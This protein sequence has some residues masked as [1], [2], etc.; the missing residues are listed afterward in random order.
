VRVVV[1]IHNDTDTPEQ[2]HWHGL[3]VPVDADGAS[4]EGTPFI[5]AHGMRR[6]AYTPRP[7]GFRFYHSHVIPKADLSKGTY[8]GQ[9][10][11]Y[12]SNQATSP[13]ATTARFFSCS[14]NLSRH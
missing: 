3:A 6:V 8:S 1:D 9:I 2:L 5:P 14:R 11:P 4:E 13:A 12:I 7:A 10:G